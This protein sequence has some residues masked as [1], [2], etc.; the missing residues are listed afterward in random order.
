MD[1]FNSTTCSIENHVAWCAAIAHQLGVPTDRT[2]YA[3][4]ALATMPPFYPNLI[5]LEPNAAIDA[6]VTELEARLDTG[7][8]I[9][10]SFVNPSLDESGFGIGLRGEWC[11]LQSS[12]VMA[13]EFLRLKV[14]IV[15]IRGELEQWTTVWGAPGSSIFLPR[16]L[17]LSDAWLLCAWQGDELASGWAASSGGGALGISN[18]FGN[19]GGILDCIRYAATQK[20]GAGLVGYGGVPEVRSLAQPGIRD[21]VSA[22]RPADTPHRTRPASAGLRS[23]AAT[24][25]P[26]GR[27]SALATPHRRHRRP[28]R[29]NCRIGLG[30]R[31]TPLVAASRR[32]G[33]HH[34]NH[35]ARERA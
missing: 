12:P 20:A 30:D 28:R 16:I 11:A 15:Q 3:W 26:P 24:H 4:V 25:R 7:R 17:N 1:E 35:V 34:G 31:G 27:A 14:S 33:I 9:E 6:E 18:A 2:P 5:T 23:A 13:S 32:T 29:R 22:P 8:G 21:S 19:P 10:D